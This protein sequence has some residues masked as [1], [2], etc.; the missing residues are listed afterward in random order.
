MGPC[1][2]SLAILSQQC[3][4]S[5]QVNIQRNVLPGM[6]ARIY[7]PST[8]E[9]QEASLGNRVRPCL[10]KKKKGMY[11][12]LTGPITSQEC[13]L[14]EGILQTPEHLLTPT[15]T[16]V[17]TCHC[18]RRWILIVQAMKWHKQPGHVA[19]RIFCKTDHGERRALPLSGRVQCH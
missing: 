3:L 10:K 15:L 19:L 6:V 2:F 1:S 16:E 8:L 7:N 18:S 12:N 14:L 9:D 4:K 13:I 5:N 11:L 17:N